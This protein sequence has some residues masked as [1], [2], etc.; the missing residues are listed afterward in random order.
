MQ[1]IRELSLGLE[2]IEPF[3]TG[4]GFEFEDY[5]IEKGPDG[6]FTFASYRNK[7]KKFLV[8]YRFSIGQV[9][10]Q[11]DNSIAS[12]PFYLDQLGFADKKRH[13]DFL[14]ENKHEAFERILHDFQYLVDDFFTGE[15]NKL[16]E[17]SKLQ[18]KIITE[19]DRKIRKENS[20]R[21]DNFRVEKA[22]QVFRMKEY[23]K[24]LEIY[25]FVD[26]NELLG[27][28]DFKIIEYCNRHA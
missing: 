12:H 21:F 10:Y 27:D 19:V 26:N 7:S 2:T 6:H 16:Q 4:Y 20:I 5:Q 14:P 3:L 8:D 17:I 15:C 9:L 24:C 18:D 25:K 1:L 13:K 23:K 11:Y 22:R 28:L